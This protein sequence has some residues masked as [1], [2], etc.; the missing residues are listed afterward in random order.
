MCIDVFSLPLFSYD[1]ASG[2]TSPRVVHDYLISFFFTTADTF[3][4]ELA[5][6]SVISVAASVSLLTL[7]AE[8][9]KRHRSNTTFGS[10]TIFFF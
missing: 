6:N 7:L 10:Q 8:E 3:L 9:L 5:I 2:K 4:I 1:Q